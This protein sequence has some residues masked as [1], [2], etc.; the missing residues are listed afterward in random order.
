LSPENDELNTVKRRMIRSYL[1]DGLLETVLGTILLVI[2]G[3][4]FGQ[5]ASPRHSRLSI[6]IG[7]LGLFVITFSSLIV[8]RILRA[9]KRR[10]TYPRAGFVSFRKREYSPSRRKNMMIL[11]FVMALFW[12]WLSVYST[13][14]NALLPAFNG[15][16]WGIALYWIA[17]NC[18]TF[19]FHALAII[20]AALGIGLA[21]AG[22]GH[23]RGMSL[24]YALFGAVLTLSGVITLTRFLRRNKPASE[25]SLEP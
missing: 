10:I 9:F 7:V 6:L 13:S 20:S 19:R 23:A 22:I 17:L 1:E 21:A 12:S 2:G 11:I 24:F 15:V 25:D 5:M 14:F 4:Y 16:L 3:A 18:G 8:K